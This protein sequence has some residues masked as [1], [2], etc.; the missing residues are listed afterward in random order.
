MSIKSLGI[1]RMTILG[2]EKGVDDE[3]WGLND[4]GW[5]VRGKREYYSRTI[6]LWAGE[7]LKTTLVKK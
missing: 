5:F 6:R 2:N 7:D 1:F 3:E 4:S